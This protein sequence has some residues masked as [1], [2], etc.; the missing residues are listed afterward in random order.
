MSIGT[1]TYSG[2]GLDCFSLNDSGTET[3]ALDE[4]DGTW[5]VAGET[6]QFEIHDSV[7]NQYGVSGSESANYAGTFTEVD[8]GT[9]GGSNWY[10]ID[11]NGEDSLA[12]TATESSDS[13]TLSDGDHLTTTEGGHYSGTLS[14]S[15]WYYGILESIGS[16]SGNTDAEEDYTLVAHGTDS[17]GPDG[18]DESTMSFNADGTYTSSTEASWSFLTL[19][20]GNDAILTDVHGAFNEYDSATD[21]T[22]GWSTVSD[23]T[24]VLSYHEYLSTFFSE[25]VSDTYGPTVG[26][27]DTF[28]ELTIQSTCGSTT[29]ITGNNWSGFTTITH[30]SNYSSESSLTG[31]WEWSDTDEFE[32][33]GGI[34]ESATSGSLLQEFQDEQDGAGK[35]LADYSSGSIF[36]YDSYGGYWLDAG[37]CYVPH[38]VPAYLSGLAPDVGLAPSGWPVTALSSNGPFGFVPSTNA[39]TAHGL[40]TEKATA[41][42]NLALNSGPDDGVSQ[43]ATSPP[44]SVLVTLAAAGRNPTDILIPTQAGTEGSGGD[45]EDDDVAGGGTFRALAE[46]GDDKPS[47][48]EVS[49]NAERNPPTAATPKP[50]VDKT[51]P[52]DQGMKPE[53]NTPNPPNTSSCEGNPIQFLVGC[54]MVTGAVLSGPF[55]PLVALKGLDEMQAGIS[56]KGTIVYNKALE[57]GLSERGAFIVDFA[58]SCPD[59]FFALSKGLFKGAAKVIAETGPRSGS[60]VLFEVG[61][62]GGKAVA[63]AAE[64]TAEAMAKNPNAVAAGASKILI[65]E[66]AAGLGEAASNDYK[67]TFF[68]ANPTLEGEVVVHHA[69]EQQ[70]LI[71]FPG[72]LTEAEMHSLQNLRAIPKSINSEL[73]LG[74]IRVEWNRFYKPFIESG[75]SPSKAQLLEKATEID[76][77]YG[78]QFTP[79][80]GGN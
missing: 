2:T 40:P 73:H 54:S 74:Q 37:Y 11:D 52:V 61:E 7:T 15:N 55:A 67:A 39:M 36:L 46:G 69:I 35:L 77:K 65:P 44:T 1:L 13:Y 24:T 30:S 21:A 5:S 51:G 72:V 19:N 79:P 38:T 20:A 12:G 50:V 6:D 58:T 25:T 23:G 14:S 34:P 57:A 47:S 16:D 53:Y 43:T 60:V 22:S 48:H 17:F 18:D 75:T 68:K 8:T 78:S 9:Y 56:G 41:L 76:L 32:I 10:S 45:D 26:G 27:T 33:V 31:G 28:G 42:D 80:V 71:R 70:V 29:D 4:S 49:M 66:Y 63:S 64:S 62:L 3:L 59:L